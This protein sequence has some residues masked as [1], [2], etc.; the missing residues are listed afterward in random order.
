MNSLDVNTIFTDLPNLG[1]T[2]SK[3]N[4]VT[5]TKGSSTTPYYYS[6]IITLS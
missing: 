3:Q 6:A 4:S 5:F 2:V 1:V